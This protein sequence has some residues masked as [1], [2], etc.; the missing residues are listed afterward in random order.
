MIVETAFCKSD[1]AEDKERTNKKW[2]CD[3]LV[4]QEKGCDISGPAEPSVDSD[5]W[6]DVKSLYPNEPGDSNIFGAVPLHY[7]VL[8]KLVSKVL[9]VEVSIPPAQGWVGAHGMQLQF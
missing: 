1:P 5:D 7:H 3:G 6:A 9:T 2:D 4:K 8:W